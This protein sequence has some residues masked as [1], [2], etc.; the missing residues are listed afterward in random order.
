MIFHPELVKTFEYYGTQVLGLFSED[1]KDDKLI[2]FIENLIAKR[3]AARAAKDWPKSDS[4][5]AELVE[6]GIEVQDTPEG[7]KWRRI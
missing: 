6:M 3:D 5:R 1:V 7:T 2:D 4:I